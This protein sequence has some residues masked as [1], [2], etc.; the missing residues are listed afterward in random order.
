MTDVVFKIRGRKDE[1]TLGTDVTDT[2]NLKIFWADLATKAGGTG[3]WQDQAF[4]V[5]APGQEP[6]NVSGADLF[7]VAMRERL[8]PPHKVQKS[9]ACKALQ[10]MPWLIKA[11]HFPGDSDNALPSA[12]V[13]TASG[14]TNCSAGK[15]K[16]NVQLPFGIFIREEVRAVFRDLPENLKAAEGIQSLL[17]TDPPGGTGRWTPDDCALNQSQARALAIAAAKVRIPSASPVAVL[18]NHT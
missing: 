8:L 16:R 14:S 9:R 2:L 5:S 6:I 3:Y 1:L 17:L 4:L 15:P 13:P 11:K 18:N 10:K 12:S 7:T